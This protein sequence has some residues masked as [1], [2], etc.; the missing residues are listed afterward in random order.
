MTYDQFDAAILLLGGF[1]SSSGTHW[2][3]PTPE[4][5]QGAVLWHSFAGKRVYCETPRSAE[6][7]GLVM[8]TRY[9]YAEALE[10]IV[11]ALEVSDD[12]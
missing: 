6:A 2:A 7:L 8:R 12:K 11:K 1:P 9:T 10:R 3:I 5:P 4:R